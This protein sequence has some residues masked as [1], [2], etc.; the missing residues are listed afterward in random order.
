M[1]FTN[2]KYVGLGIGRGA[3]YCPCFSVV[4]IPL[5]VAKDWL[6][7]LVVSEPENICLWYIY[8]AR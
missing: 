1:S 3:N 5:Q 4:H 6:R 7:Q 2:L 8:N